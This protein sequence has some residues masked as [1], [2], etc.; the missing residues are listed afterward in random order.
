M[1]SIYVTNTQETWDGYIESA[2]GINS[3]AG[4]AIDNKLKVVREYMMD[5]FDIDIDK[6]RSTILR[7]EKEV[8]DG[9]VDLTSVEIY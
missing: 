3:V 1:L 5:T 2:G 7:R 4:T 8:V 6:L 9:Q